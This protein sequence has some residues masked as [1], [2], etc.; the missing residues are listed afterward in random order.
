MKSIKDYSVLANGVQMPW[1]GLGVFKTAEGEEVEN[2][3]RYALE[4]GY[5]HIDTAAIYGNEAGVGQAVK[6]SGLAREEL[7]ITTKV[8]NSEQGYDT[9]LAAFE[10]SRKKL[11]VEY[12]D[13][14]LIHWAVKEKYKE[15]WKA[16]E[17]LYQDGYV[18][19]IGVSNFQVHHLQDLMETCSVKPMVNQCEYHPYLTQKELL[20][21][22]QQE[23]I[24]FEAWSPI[25]RGKVNDEPE[26]VKLAEK[27][28]K[29]PAQVVLRWDLQHGVVTIPK[30]VRRERVIE[31]A[32]LFDFELAVE[33]METLDRL[34]RD[35]RFGSDPDNIKF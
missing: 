3:V 10:E 20:S 12:V 21:F 16:L 14:Y 8:W 33:D 31:N 34:N 35:Q 25:M 13:L 7:F 9:T 26:I 28:G 23:G 6:A 4:A 17:K 27:Y 32:Q 2:S 30:S 1:L 18:R 5:R 15:T 29:T 19:A 24:Q 11:G 22:C